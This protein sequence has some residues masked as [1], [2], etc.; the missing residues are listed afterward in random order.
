MLRSAAYPLMA[1][2]TVPTCESWDAEDTLISVDYLI[3]IDMCLAR[4]YRTPP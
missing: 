1:E 4:S 3:E 2:E